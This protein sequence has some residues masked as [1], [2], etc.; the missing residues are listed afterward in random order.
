MG[1][2]NFDHTIY[3]S[4]K[5]DRVRGRLNSAGT[6]TTPRS[7]LNFI[8]GT[9]IDITIAD[10]ATNDE[11]DITIATTGGD[12][13]DAPEIIRAW[14]YVG[15][16]AADYP[17]TGFAL[18]RVPLGMQSAVATGSSAF[19][20]GQ[21]HVWGF[22]VGRTGAIDKIEWEVTGSGGTTARAYLAIYEN[23]SRT[24]LYPDA[25]IVSS[26]EQD[27]SGTAKL[28]SATVSA[29]LERGHLYWAAYHTN[30]ATPVVKTITQS[31]QFSFCDTNAAAAAGSRMQLFNAFTFNKAYAATAADPFHAAGSGTAGASAVAHQGISPFIC[32]H[33][34]T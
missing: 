16:A 31:S 22:I 4:E 19:V 3:L 5:R 33:Y 8:E 17:T 26:G 9:G 20:N 18:A 25:L 10:D 14:D 2:P 7:R 15:S 12:D 34:S 27:V 6:T 29:T 23:A 24:R 11:I 1:R 28:I 21:L 30:S 32:I 13:D